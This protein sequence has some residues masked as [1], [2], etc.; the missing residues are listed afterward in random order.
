[1][2]I[3]EICSLIKPIL[4]KSIGKGD[5][6]LFPTLLISI[7]KIQFGSSAKKS[8]EA[9]MNFFRKNGFYADRTTM[10]PEKGYPALFHELINPP[11]WV[12]SLDVS[13][14]EKDL[15]QERIIELACL[16]EYVKNLGIE[17]VKNKIRNSDSSAPD[18]AN[19]MTKHDFY[20]LYD[21]IF[22]YSGS[23]E[24]D[25]FHDLLPVPGT[26]DLFIFDAKE[27]LWFFAEVKGPN[28][29]LKESQK[30]WLKNNWEKIR[31]NYILIEIDVI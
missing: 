4:S 24:E 1:V 25:T 15:S 12:P 16:I 26:P 30:R 5:S 3:N 20:N 23:D 2:Q 9:A 14:I 18:L 13:E 27:S 11:D 6:Y 28:D 10:S 8:E 29:S 17:N 7:S 21:A 22:F 31:G 19:F